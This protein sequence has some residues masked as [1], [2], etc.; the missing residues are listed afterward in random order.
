MICAVVIVI[1][2]LLRNNA[3]NKFLKGTGTTILVL[4]SLGALGALGSPILAAIQIIWQVV[5]G[6]AMFGGIIYWVYMEF[7]NKDK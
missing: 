6:I 3:T 2:L 7:I 5:V 1:G 4:G